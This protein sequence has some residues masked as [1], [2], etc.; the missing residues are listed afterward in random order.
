MV[1]EE[2]VLPS[3]PQ[4]MTVCWK[5]AT[6]PPPKRSERPRSVLRILVDE[7]RMWEK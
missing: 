3:T 1:Q 4:G 7:K 2:V 6:V 5:A